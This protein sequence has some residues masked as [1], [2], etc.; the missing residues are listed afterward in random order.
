MSAVHT[1][2]TFEGEIVG[3]LT[4][5][6]GWLEGDPKK[7]DRKLALY[8]EDVIGWIQDTQPAEYQK[9]KGAQNG[10]TDAIILER[11]GKALQEEGPLAVLR[12][13]FKRINA[14]FAMCAFRPGHGLNPE[15]LEKYA[16]VRCRVVRQVHYSENNEKSIDLVLFVNG[17]PVATVELKTDF[18]QS[19]EDAT[20]QYRFDRLPKDAKTSKAEPLLTFKRGA[21][22][23]FAASTDEV[24]MTTFLDGPKT[25][26]LPFNLGNNG[27]AG[28]PPNPDGHR[29][30]YLWERVFQ[31]DA[32]LE[33]LEKFIHLEKRTKIVDGK[34]I[35]TERMI[36]PRYHQWY[37]V[38]HLVAAAKTEGAGQKYLVQHS[39]GSGKSNTIMWLAHQ[40]ASAHSAADKKIF[41]SVIVVTD[42]QVLDDQLQETI[43]QFEHKDGFVV[44]I[45]KEGSKSAQLAEAF[46][47]KT[48]II[49]VTIQTFPYA[50]DT[51]GDLKDMANRSFAVIADEAHS[52]QTGEA[53]KKLREVLGIT[54]T[55]KG[56]EG[57]AVSAEE[58]LLAQMSKRAGAKNLS[59]FAFTAT[60]KAKTIE[61][62]GRPD[63]TG[64]R[65][66]FTCTR[67][68][69]RSRRASS[70]TSSRTIRR[71]RSPTNSR[72][73]P[74]RRA[75]GRPHGRGG[76]AHQA[77]RQA[78]SVQHR[79][80][81]RDH[82][83][84]LPRDRPA[85]AWGS[86]EGHGR[87][88]QPQGGR[89]V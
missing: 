5:A 8:P 22:V 62:F 77:V 25:V 38:R 57:E 48:S 63:P 39:A 51:I 89:A 37:A 82:R 29:T 79:A 75:K 53:A 50:L 31:R 20:K 87:V 16:K 70:S 19:I 68:N 71:T 40:L 3:H 28:N 47:K 23:H 34:K 69:R 55:P 61:L 9:V 78:P 14:R 44:R 65:L 33:I 74:T 15:T 66:H 11:L 10:A 73:L 81:G 46:R 42:R 32:W 4:S 21:L 2:A 13:G 41:D 17:I 18:T 67:C 6:G 86:R 35:T 36:F 72:R 30:A 12:N 49:I 84:A 60:P 56:E 80:E 83:R 59:Y 88:R 7:Y 54:D 27:A 45:T 76:E 85:T 24:R 43:F 58:A 1:E 64:S 52:S 26:Y